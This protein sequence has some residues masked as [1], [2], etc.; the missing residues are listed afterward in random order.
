MFSLLICNRSSLADILLIKRSANARSYREDCKYP[1][2]TI[3]GR[4]PLVDKQTGRP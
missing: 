1:T 2:A 4:R 3:A